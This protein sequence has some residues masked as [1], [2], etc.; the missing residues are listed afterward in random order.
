MANRATP[1]SVRMNEDEINTVLHGWGCKVR[2]QALPAMF[3]VIIPSCM[4]ILECVSQCMVSVACYPPFFM[5]GGE[6]SIK[7]KGSNTSILFTKSLIQT[8]KSMLI[9]SC[10]KHG[11]LFSHLVCGHWSTDM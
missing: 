10:P 7:Y 2:W 5:H 4:Y 11:Q 6:R 3:S 9:E 8:L 1:V